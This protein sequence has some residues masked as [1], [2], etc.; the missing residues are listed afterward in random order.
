M[1]QSLRWGIVGVSEIA[2]DFC[3]AL[4]LKFTRCDHEIVAVSSQSRGRAE[5]FAKEHGIPKVCPDYKSL[6]ADDQVEVVYISVLNPLRYEVCKMMIEYKKHIV[7]EKPLCI[8]RQQVKEILDLAKKSGVFVM[9]GL[10]S[11]FF[12]VYRYLHQLMNMKILSNVKEVYVKHGYNATCKEKILKKDKGGGVVLDIGVDAIQFVVFIYQE[13]PKSIKA[14]GKINS[15]GVDLYIQVDMFFSG[16]RK[17]TI[18]CS[19]LQAFENQATVISKKGPICIPDYNCPTKLFGCNG[20]HEWSLISS[21]IPLNFTNS[22]GLRYEADEVMK[23]IRSGKLECEIVPAK[24]M[25]LIAQIRDEIRKQIGV[26][27]D[28]DKS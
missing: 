2:H 27:Y 9:E 11:R 28:S 6:A 7:C 8:D 23:C 26:R 24:D 18:I 25:L 13:E 1:S 5:L 10:W 3:V 22:L 14:S 17:A 15:D 16:D 19:G 4:N 21:K 12:P 20:A